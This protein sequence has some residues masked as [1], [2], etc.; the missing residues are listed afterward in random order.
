M[1]KMLLNKNKFNEDDFIKELLNPL[2]DPIKTEQI[3]SNLEINLNE[4]YIEE[5]FILHKCSKKGLIKSVEWLINNNIDIEKVNNQG[6]TAIFYAIQSRN[7]GT[8]KLLLDNGA[9]VDHLDNYKRTALQDAVISANKRIVEYLLEKSHLLNNADFRGNNLFFDALANGNLDLISKIGSLSKDININQINEEGHTILH[10]ESVLKDNKLAILLLDLGANPTIKDKEGKNFLFYI[11][12]KGIENIDI[13]NKAVKLGCDINARSSDNTTILMESIN[14]FLTTDKNDEKKRLSHLEMIKMLL[15]KGVDINALD[16]NLENAFFCATRSEEKEL[17]NIFLDN[18]KLEINHPNIQG[19]TVLQILILSGFKNIELIKAYLEKHAN[20]NSKN[21]FNKTIIETLI[22][23]VLYI[24]NKKIIE[25]ELEASLNENGEYSTVL[26]VVLKNGNVDLEQ[27]NS[28]NEPLFFDSIIYFN[29]RLFKS[30]KNANI[31]V[32]LK[33]INGNNIIFKLMEYNQKHPIKDKKLY[34]GTIKSLINIGV[35]INAKNKEELTPLQKAIENDCEYT[36]KLLLELKA[37]CLKSD[38]KGRT[39]IHNCILKNKTK[40]FKLIHSYNK[41]VVNQVD[42]FG[43]R[44]IN[45]AAFMG[46]KNLV[47]KMLEEG[48]L[49]NNPTEKDPSILQFFQKFHKNILNLRK[50]ENSIDK[51]N[52]GLLVDSMIKEFNIK[53]EE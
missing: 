53:E 19:N 40:Y 27:L 41:E 32:N 36:V 43:V 46:K 33:D 37:D 52:L 29:F 6:Q 17:I 4:L 21:Q 42:G 26:D 7:T 18:D 13:L 45:Y 35:D 8:L 25:Q 24:E 23:I 5:E 38:K 44:A 51:V 22:D 20:P 10:K 31:N 48:A 47:I 2:F 1:I 28:K 12:S 3:Y 50:V 34:L 15:S 14:Y 11:I 9:L 30:L 39:V 16:E 49:I